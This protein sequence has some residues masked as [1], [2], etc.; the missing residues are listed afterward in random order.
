MLSTRTGGAG[1]VDGLEHFEAAAVGQADV[2]QHDI[3]LPGFDQIQCRGAI[4]RLTDFH[5]LGDF[6]QDS[7]QARARHAVVIDDQDSKHL[8]LPRGHGA[9]VTVA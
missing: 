2:E 5:R 1:F 6:G 7:P 8:T 3:P 4:G 9:A